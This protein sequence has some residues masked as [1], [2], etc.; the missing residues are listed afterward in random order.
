[1]PH[2]SLDHGANN[3]TGRDARSAFDSPQVRGQR[4]PWAVG[5]STAARGAVAR[6]AGGLRVAT[7]DRWGKEVAS[8]NNEEARVA[9]KQEG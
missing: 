1:M 3:L 8:Q 6:K 7:E 4:T 2:C 5:V 9:G